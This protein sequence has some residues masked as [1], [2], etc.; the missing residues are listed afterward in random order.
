MT[1]NDTSTEMSN[2][3]TDDDSTTTSNKTRWEYTGTVSALSLVF[4]LVGTIVG[5]AAGAFTLSAI[6]QAFFLLFAVAVTA[7]IAWVF[8]EG[9]L[10]AARETFGK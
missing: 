3:S 8:G 6:P 5:A 10:A 2:D 7:A 9:K 1:D 4:A